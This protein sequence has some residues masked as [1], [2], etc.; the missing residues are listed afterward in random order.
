M[1]T[2][3]SN[4][5]IENNWITW[6]LVYGICIEGWS[7][8]DT[9]PS[10]PL[11]IA[12]IVAHTGRDQGIGYGNG[13]NIRYSSRPVIK[14]T[15]ILSTGEDAVY[16][17]DGSTPTLINV[18]ID[19]ANYGIASSSTRYIYLYNLTIKNT[20]SYDFAI[21]DS[22]FII[23][24]TTFNES[25]ISINSGSNY[26]VRWYLHVKVQDSNLSP[27]PAADVRIRDNGN[28]TYDKNFTTDS[29][30]YVKWIVLTE[31]RRNNDTVIYYTPYN[32]TVNY[33]GLTFV[34]DPRNSTMNTSKTEVFTATT[35]FPEFGNLLVPVIF[36]I[37]LSVLFGRRRGGGSEGGHQMDSQGRGARPCQ[38]RVREDIEFSNFPRYPRWALNARDCG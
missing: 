28:G 8:T 27:I 16:S 6:N 9:H 12:N 36:V 29:N 3:W 15:E 37:A 25:K 1:A 26:T 20:K 24:N 14:D 13:I 4:G 22:Y 5:A 32:I 31:Y 19:G 17:S 23:T 33:T 11:V 35:P 10:N 21:L 38:S 30:G 18:T 34:N 2:W 7:N